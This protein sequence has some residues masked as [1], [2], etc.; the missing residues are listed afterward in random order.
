MRIKVGK[1]FFDSGICKC[2]CLNGIYIS[3]G[4]QVKHFL[5][6]AFFLN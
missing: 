2:I 5:N 1:H 6:R 3:F 4:D